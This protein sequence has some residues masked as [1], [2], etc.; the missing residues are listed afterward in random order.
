VQAAVDY[1]DVHGVTGGYT[2]LSHA[3]PG[4]RPKTRA[5]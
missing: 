2:H 1:Y 5:A 3:K 4:E